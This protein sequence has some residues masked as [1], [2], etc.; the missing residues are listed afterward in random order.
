MKVLVINSGSSS[1]KFQLFDMSTET[2]LIKG[3]VD[4]IGLNSCKFIF[5]G[6]EE[7][8]TEMNFYKINFYS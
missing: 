7:S 6:K 3:M 8:S 5:N 4:E 2:A 1:I